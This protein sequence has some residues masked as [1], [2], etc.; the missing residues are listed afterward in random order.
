MEHDLVAYTVT[1]KDRTVRRREV[2]QTLAKC[3]RAWRL[4][5]ALVR[6]DSAYDVKTLCT[7]LKNVLD[8][9][10]GDTWYITPIPVEEIHTGK[11]QSR[12]RTN[13][14]HIRLKHQI[15]GIF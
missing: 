4:D 12:S 10:G 1:G 2:E 5:E 7:R 15:F 14:P 11:I 8:I 6:I 13:M 9:D 3:G